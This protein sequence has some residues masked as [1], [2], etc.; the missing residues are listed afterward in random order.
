MRVVETREEAY[1]LIVKRVRT[2]PRD[3]RYSTYEIDDSLR[4]T[5]IKFAERRERIEHIVDRIER[6]RR[7]E[8]VFRRA[9]AGEKHVIIALDEG[10]APNTVSDIVRKF[11]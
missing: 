6:Y 11:K 7:D 9:S 2:C 3:H 4:K 10:I 8:R 5:L 1:G